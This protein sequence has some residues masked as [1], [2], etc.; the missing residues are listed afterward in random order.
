MPSITSAILDLLGL[1][2]KQLMFI[3]EIEQT[4]VTQLMIA[5]AYFRN[6]RIMHRRVPPIKPPDRHHDSG[7]TL[8]TS[9]AQ[10]S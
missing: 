8:S 10:S 1:N 5:A 7:A 2:E 4:D 6:G 3:R 9:L